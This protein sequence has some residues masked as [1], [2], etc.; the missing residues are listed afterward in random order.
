MRLRRAHP[1][2]CLRSTPVRSAGSGVVIN[3]LDRRRPDD[4]GAPRP[5]GGIGAHGD[6]AQIVLKSAHGVERFIRRFGAA[7]LSRRSLGATRARLRLDGFIG[8]FGTAIL[9][10]R[11]LGCTHARLRLDIRLCRAPFLRDRR[12]C[13]AHRRDAA[14]LC[15]VLR[16]RRN[17]RC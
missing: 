10:R 14:P 15:R 8:R 3:V 16:F 5:V 12:R 1:P 13:V 9:S 4:D 11:S 2:L 6:V 7:V 17:R